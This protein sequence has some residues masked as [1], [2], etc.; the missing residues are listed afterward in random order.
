MNFLNF[1]KQYFI[2]V[3]LQLSPFSPITFPYPSHPHL[4]HSVLPAT[5]VFVHGSFTHVP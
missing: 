5:I 2:V 3:Q 4:P 1:L